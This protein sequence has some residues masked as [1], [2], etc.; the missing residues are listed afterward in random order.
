LLLSTVALLLL[1]STV[2]SATVAI[3]NTMCVSCDV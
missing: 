2:A 3:K 1:L